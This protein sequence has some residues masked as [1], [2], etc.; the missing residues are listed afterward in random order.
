MLLHINSFL[1]FFAIFLRGNIILPQNHYIKRGRILG[2][3]FTFNRNPFFRIK[4]VQ[5]RSR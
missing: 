4:I 3:T 2:P 5:A 1:E